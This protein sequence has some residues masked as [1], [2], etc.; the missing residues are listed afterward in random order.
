MTQIRNVPDDL[1]RTLRVRAVQAGLSL[2][3]YLLEQ[4]RR[5]EDRPTREE[6]I[7]RGSPML[8]GE[9]CAS[10]RDRIMPPGE[11]AEPSRA[12]LRCGWRRECR[13]KAE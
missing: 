5:I 4:L 11:A 8:Q 1:H 12:P 2:S 13:G 3:E 10:E 6:S 9:R 7:E